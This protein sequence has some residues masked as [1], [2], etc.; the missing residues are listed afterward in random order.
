MSRRFEGRTVL[1]TG[2][3]RGFGRVTA[4]AFAREGARLVIGDLDAAPL[5]ETAGRVRALGAEVVTLEGDVTDPATARA[6]VAA[7]VERF[8][9]LDVAVNNAGVVHPQTKFQALSERDLRFMLDVN[10]VGVFHF[11]QAE[12]AAM[13]ARFGREGRGG[14]IV[15]VASVAGLIA[16]PSLA[17]YAAS[18]HAVIGLTKAV[19]AEVARRGIRINCVCPS[20][21]ET[22]MV[23]DALD[24]MPPGGTREE[25]LARLV[26]G[27]PMRRLG[28]PEEVAA[29]ILFLASD[30]S[31]FTTGHA[32]TVD[33]GLEMS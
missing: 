24:R 12:I 17:A 27:I 15:N 30:D 8:G 3:A 18:K 6:A 4:E 32:L 33:G 14:T 7:A 13:E 26:Q 19:A 28:A 23:T 11:L 1:V 29:A 20:F 22:R 9:G 2:A 5:A 21:A 31:S 10:V 25:T 16:S